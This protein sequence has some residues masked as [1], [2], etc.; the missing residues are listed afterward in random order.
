MITEQQSF[1]DGS[2]HDDKYLHDT[3]LN[4]MIAGR[5]TTSSSLTWF[6]CLIVTH[7]EVEKKIG[8]EINQVIP[9]YQILFSLYAMGRMQTIWGDDSWEF[10]PERW[11][12]EK[13]TIRHEPSYK[14]LSF[15]A[16]P[17]TCIG[18]Q[19][20]FTQMKAIGAT[21]FHNYNFE[22]VKGHIVAPNVSVILYM[23]DGLKVRVSRRWP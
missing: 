10:K 15:N 17:R 18:K 20:A 1:T 2:K 12:T 22:I 9:E 16:G 8:D 13:Q 19:V 21:I 5:D 7:P 6:L 4:L 3:I 14:F 11:I 23:K